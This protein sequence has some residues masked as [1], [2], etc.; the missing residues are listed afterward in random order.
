MGN[1][2]IAYVFKAIDDFSPALKKINEAMSNFE[3]QTKKAE[4]NVK[5]IK[6]VELPKEIILVKETPKPVR[7]PS[8]IVTV[9]DTAH[10]TVHE[11]VHETVHDTTQKKNP[12]I[13]DTISSKIP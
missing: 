13:K 5:Q 10:D 9:H 1:Y 8:E 6:E 2:D 12:S 11:T 7:T 3:K 4:E